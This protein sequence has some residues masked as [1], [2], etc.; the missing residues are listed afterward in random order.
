MN[1]CITTEGSFSVKLLFAC[2]NMWYIIMN[3]PISYAIQ[4][5]ILGD[6]V[7]AHLS[8]LE[9]I[10]VTLDHYSPTLQKYPGVITPSQTHTNCS[11]CV[12]LVASPFDIMLKYLALLVELS[13]SQLQPHLCI[14]SWFVQW[15][16]PAEFLTCVLCMQLLD[17][18]LKTCKLVAGLRSR[19]DEDETA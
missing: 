12:C 15:W 5:V 18:F 3:L 16:R 14:L 7:N 17:A 1:T 8:L 4:V 2:N 10:Y 6:K 11:Y 9:K 19:H 13:V